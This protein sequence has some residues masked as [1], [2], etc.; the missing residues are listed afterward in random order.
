MRYCV[1]EFAEHGLHIVDAEPLISR[2]NISGHARTCI[3]LEGSRATIIN[4]TIS[5]S[6]GNGVLVG[7]RSRAHITGNEIYNCTDNGIA[8]GDNSNP[9]ITDNLITNVADH[10]IYLYE[11]AACSLNYN[12]LLQCGERG[13]YIFQA[14]RTVLMR[15]IVYRC[16][17]DF[18]VYLYRAQNTV[19]LN[20]TIYDNDQNGLGIVNASGQL[21]NNLIVLN[22]ENGVFVQGGNVVFDYND[23]WMNGRND[24]VGLEPGQTNLSVNPQLVGPA[25]GDFS[26]AQGSPV[27]DAGNPR[28]RDPDGT[29]ADIGA[30]FFNQNHPP[31]IT[32]YAPEDFDFLDGD[33]EI[34]FSVVASDPDNHPLIYTWYLNGEADGD[35][36]SYTHLFNRDGTYSV[37]IVVDDN[38]YLGR[39][40]HEWN[41]EVQGS[42]AP[43]LEAA[44]PAR[45]VLRGPY[46]NP[47]NSQAWFSLETGNP[48]SVEITLFS[49]SGSPVQEIRLGTVAAGTHRFALNGDSIPAGVY[50][51]IAD[52]RR[53]RLVKKV[54]IIK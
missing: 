30:M 46:P 12:T 18:S 7:E 43:G 15:N 5:G 40:A 35:R 34:T 20:N 53:A 29:R 25:L 13:I 23:V 27:I 47:F 28:Y 36:S 45:V 38:Y 8:I 50:L 1:V 6:Q 44:M 49:L 24:Y 37:M 39:T 33:Q 21:W 22:E 17:G 31:E 42:S 52:T 48:G 9:I 11:A 10:G 14:D 2:C 51:L 19:M 41:F 3:R 32:S 16:Q 54:V 4:C 26:P